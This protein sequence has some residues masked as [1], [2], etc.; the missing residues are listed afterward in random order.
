MLSCETMLFWNSSH[1]MIFHMDFHMYITFHMWNHVKPCCFGTLHVMIFH[2][3][4]IWRCPANKNESLGCTR[5][6]TQSQCFQLTCWKHFDIHADIVHVNLYSNY[7]STHLE[8]EITTSWFTAF[9]SS[10]YA[11]MSVSIIDFTCI[12]TLWTSK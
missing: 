3:W 11:P 9:W 8:Y 4:I 1:V 5:N 6:I 10:C 12:P 2:M 7:Y